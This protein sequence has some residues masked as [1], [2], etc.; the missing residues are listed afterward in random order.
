MLSNDLLLSDSTAMQIIISQTPHVSLLSWP[1][2]TFFEGV[3]IL[4][5]LLFLWLH[6]KTHTDKINFEESTH[7]S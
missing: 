1:A 7:Q 4:S 6:K 3:V 5:Y 2:I